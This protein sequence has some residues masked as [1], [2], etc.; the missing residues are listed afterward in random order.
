MYGIHMW[1]ISMNFHQPLKSAAFS[2]Q[3]SEN[4]PNLLRIN[5]K[6]TLRCSNERPLEGAIYINL[7]V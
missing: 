2:L 6:G 5:L 1:W 4:S 3:T 7:H